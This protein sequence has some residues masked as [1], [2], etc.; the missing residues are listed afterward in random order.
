MREK[1]AAIR[2]AS[3]IGGDDP[4]RLC[5]GVTAPDCFSSTCH[6]QSSVT[7][8]AAKEALL[9]IATVGRAWLQVE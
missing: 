8:P 2:K 3:V 1:Q 7:R 9:Q 6:R 5:R 4:P